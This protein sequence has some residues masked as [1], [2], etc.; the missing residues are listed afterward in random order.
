MASLLADHKNTLVSRLLRFN[1][2]EQRSKERRTLFK[3]HVLPPRYAN[4][5]QRSIATFEGTRNAFPASCAQEK[6]FQALAYL[7]I[8]LQIVKSLP[9]S[10]MLLVSSC[11]PP[12][13]NIISQLLFQSSSNAMEATISFW[14]ESILVFYR[15]FMKWMMAG[16]IDESLWKV[17]FPTGR[18]YS[19][20]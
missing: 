13:L 16:I 7:Y 19:S 11:K 15:C 14:N 18:F 10:S 1:V 6:I 12:L 8:L 4:G 5:M 17:R 20:G 9:I 3:L 2:L